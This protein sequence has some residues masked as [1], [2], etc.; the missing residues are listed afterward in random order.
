MRESL[1]AAC[2]HQHIS[3]LLQKSLLEPASL[4]NLKTAWSNRPVF[5][6][7]T[8]ALRSALLLLLLLLLPIL[9]SNVCYSFDRTAA[10]FTDLA[11]PWCSSQ[12]H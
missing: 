9:P 3:S 2:R 11:L 8:S 12:D 7:G 1:G 6:P 4:S 5:D 10:V